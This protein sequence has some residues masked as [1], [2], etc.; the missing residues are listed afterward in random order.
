VKE[1][2]Q[3][4]LPLHDM[5]IFGG[6]LELAKNPTLLLN[7]FLSVPCAS[8]GKGFVQGFRSGGRPAKDELIKDEVKD[9]PVCTV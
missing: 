3:L 9:E 8:K 7:A 4:T 5:R 2:V 6:A 1:S